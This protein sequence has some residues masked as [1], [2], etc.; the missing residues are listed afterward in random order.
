MR[1]SFKIKSTVAI[2]IVQ[3]TGSDLAVLRIFQGK[4]GSDQKAG[5]TVSSYSKKS[6]IIFKRDTFHVQSDHFGYYDLIHLV[7]LMW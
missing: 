3:C 1:F 6:K 5:D 2:L 4:L 7:W